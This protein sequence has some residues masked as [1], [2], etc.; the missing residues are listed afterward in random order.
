MPRS[1]Y[2]SHGNRSEHLVHEDIIV[3]SIGIYGQNFYYIPRELVAK[4]E[5]LGEDRLSKFK[6]AFAIEMY[7][8]NAEGFEGQGAFIQRFGGMMMEQSATLTVARRRWEQL[9]GRFGVTTIPSRPNE[10]DLLYFPLTDGLFEIK[11]VQHQ[12]PFYQI[13]K[14]FVYKLE[15]EL[16]QYASER[17]ET[18]VKPIDDFESLKSFSTDVIANGTVKQI[19]ITNEGNNYSEVPTVTIDPPSVTKSTATATASINYHGQISAIDVTYG[20]VEYT[21][22]PTVTIDAPTSGVPATATATVNNNKVTSIVI[23]EP[24]SGYLEAPNVTISAPSSYTTAT[25]IAHLGSGQ[26]EDNVVRIEI[27]NPGSGYTSAPGV[28]ISGGGGGNGATAVASIENLDNQDSF[29]DNNKFKEEANDILFS[30]DN[31]FGEVN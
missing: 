9:V 16:F 5:I 22:P 2:F 29:G 31:P 23:T 4:D 28:T 18:G 14:L 20:G 27:T 19:R 25:A 17:I 15:V 6:K 21:D 24:G 11:F 10:G 1:V 26:T 30:E 7:L 3:E 12:D 8:E 13:G